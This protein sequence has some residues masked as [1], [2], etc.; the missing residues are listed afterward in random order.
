[1]ETHS[2]RDCD[3][4]LNTGKSKNYEDMEPIL[5]ALV[6]IFINLLQRNSFSNFAP[7]WSK[8]AQSNYTLVEIN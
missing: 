5:H 1:M 2:G 4:K 6:V 3:I 8:N 7:T